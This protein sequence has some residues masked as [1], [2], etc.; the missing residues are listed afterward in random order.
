MR[1]LLASS[2]LK[3]SIHVRFSNYRH[4]FGQ[5][6]NTLLMEL[7]H[8]KKACRAVRFS[9]DGLCTFLQVCFN[10]PEVPNVD[11][12]KHIHVFLTCQL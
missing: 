2:C 5:E 9:A 8:H 6:G 7:R 1:L 11:Q 3:V 10:M 4:N 12:V